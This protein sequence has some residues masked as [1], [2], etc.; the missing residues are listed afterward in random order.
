MM[1]RIT[2]VY[3]AIIG[4]RRISSTP[5]PLIPSAPKRRRRRSTPRL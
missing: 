4:R 3:T 1:M 2:I 5:R